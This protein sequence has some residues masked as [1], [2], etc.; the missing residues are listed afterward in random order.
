MEQ[1]KLPFDEF[2][3]KALGD[4]FYYWFGYFHYKGSE[5]RWARDMVK[6][7]YDSQILYLSEDFR[8][9]RFCKRGDR[10]R[11]FK[12]IISD[13]KTRNESAG[14]YNTVIVEER[15]KEYDPREILPYT[16]EE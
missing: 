4:L 2:K 13:Q 3:I 16:V 5:K 15:R 11:K 12:I 6:R 8:K 7:T 1:L 14:F 10:D 9:Y